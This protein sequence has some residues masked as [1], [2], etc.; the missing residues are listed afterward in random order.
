[1]LNKVQKLEKKNSLG[2]N[3][4]LNGIKTICSIIF[5]FISFTYCSRVLGAD[6]LGAYS[7][8]QS[9]I[10]YLL[11]IA[12]LGIPNYAIR[13]GAYRKD[14][15]QEFKKFVNQVFTINCITMTISYCILF[16]LIA[17]LPKIHSYKYIILIQSMQILLTTIGADW[18]NTIYEDYL[19]LTIRY[20]II[21]FI[22][23]ILLIL[24]VKN[25]TD[26][27][28]Y[29]LISVLANC[30]GYLLNWRY[31]KKRGIHL[32]IT[33]K[34][35]WNKH[36]KSIL[37]LFFNSIA[38]VIYLNSDITML[39]AYTNDTEVGVYTVSS[40]IYTMMKTLVNSVILITLPRFSSYLAKKELKKYRESLS[41]VAEILIMI[42]CPII[43]GVCMEADKILTLVAGIDYIYGNTVLR[44]LGI[45]IFFAVG[46]CLFSYSILIPKGKEKYFM[47]STVIAA[48]INISLNFIL[49][50]KYGMNAAAITTLIAEIIVFSMTAI[51]SY[52]TIKFDINYKNIYKIFIGCIIEF[53]L[54]MMLDKLPLHG[55][56]IIIIEVITC[57][58]AYFIILLILK[59]E[60]I[61][62]FAE[63][64]IRK[65]KREGK[66]ND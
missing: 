63:Q 4:F 17:F 24:F 43:V 20:I 35:E 55:N 60:Y 7:Y 31:L 39:G 64:V 46:A 37:I 3:A 62:V 14:N 34:I 15:K 25:G 26:I 47:T 49:L 52:K 38:T 10:A 22:S 21:Q 54:C 23:L 41:R 56:L 32:K 29:T 45:A 51:Y 33:K 9:I 65:L 16:F 8:G 50:P 19:Y 13:E 18:I 1:M 27:Y 11:L 66:Y 40:K 48:I 58:I 42:V 44:I 6:R 53:L 28:I 5:P 59:Y 36:I 2:K 57:S 12:S 61:Y 30:G